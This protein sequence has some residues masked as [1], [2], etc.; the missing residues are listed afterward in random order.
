MCILCYESLTG[1]LPG[2]PLATMLK[3]HR[4]EKLTKES[5]VIAEALLKSDLMEVSI[6]Y[7]LSNINVC[8]SVCNEFRIPIMHHSLM[9]SLNLT[10][11]VV[12]SIAHDP[13]L[14]LFHFR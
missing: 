2:I 14:H 4:L 1:W 7:L 10:S 12:H 3:F 11:P 9:S 6:H 5:S 13:F 8:L